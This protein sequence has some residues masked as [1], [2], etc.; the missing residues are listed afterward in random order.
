MKNNV[1][2][3]LK[4]LKIKNRHHQSIK[5]DKLD[6]ESLHVLKTHGSAFLALQIFYLSSIDMEKLKKQLLHLQIFLT[7]M[8]FFN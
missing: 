8:K 3:E 7:K 2:E 5:I 6:Y 4:K 1:P